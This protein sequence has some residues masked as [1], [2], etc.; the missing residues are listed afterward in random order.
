MQ[1][2][3][4]QLQFRI[5]F[6][7]IRISSKLKLKTAAHCAQIIKCCA[8]LHNFFILTHD[9]WDVPAAAAQEYEEDDI[10]DQDDLVHAGA[11]AGNIRLTILNNAF[12]QVNNL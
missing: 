7:V 12:I 1:R 6:I 3:D 11:D 4:L 5:I 8:C 9:D 10:N 2:Y